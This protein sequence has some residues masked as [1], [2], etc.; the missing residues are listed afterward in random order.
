MRN[1]A[2]APG[3]RVAS[4]AIQGRV[5]TQSAPPESERPTGSR[6]PAPVRREAR[7]AARVA[8][9]AARSRR[10]AA[11]PSTRPPR[12]RRGGIRRSAERRSDATPGS[13]RQSSR[14]AG[15]TTPCRGARSATAS[16]RTREQRPGASTARCPRVRRT[17]RATAR[18]GYGTTERGCRIRRDRAGGPV[19]ST[20]RCG[21]AVSRP[22]SRAASAPS[23]CATPA[24]RPEQSRRRCAGSK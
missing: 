23:R 22:N 15:R 18:R 3:G 13:P 19:S 7:S 10:A 20:R 24:V 12:R 21:G 16:G 9:L 6:R 11:S 4:A 8:A 2:S 1:V 5:R 17:Q 14:C